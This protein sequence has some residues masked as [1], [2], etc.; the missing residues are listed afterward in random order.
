MRG[1]WICPERLF[2]GAK[3][4]ENM[5]LRLVD[6]RIDA[7]AL[8]SA[9]MADCRPIAGTLTPGFVDLQ[10][11]GG[12]G[13]L[14]NQTPT[15]EGLRQIVDAHR[16]LGTVAILPTVI[17]DTPEVLAAAVDAVIAAKKLRGI[18]GLHIEGP[19]IA[20]TR[21][22]THA[23]KFMR[24]FDPQTLAHV[25]RLRDEGVRVMITLAPEAAS[26]AD[27]T[28][29]TNLGAVVSLGHT[30][31]SADITRAAFGAGARCVTH[32]SNA[33]P[34]MFNREVGVMGAAI[35]SDAYAG[36]ICDGIH[37]ADEMV[38]LIVRARAVS[39]RMFLVSDAMPT[40]GGSD[41]FDLYGSEIRL[42][43]GRLVNAEGSLAGAHITQAEGV[44]RLVQH[45]GIGLEQAL[46]M[47]ITAPATLMGVD[48]LTI[49]EGRPIGDFLVL[50]DALEIRGTLAEIEIA[51]AA[52]T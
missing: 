33:M 26:D 37:V 18:V 7:V 1:I 20:A 29:L 17:S 49:V 47:A 15:Q 28:A 27:I 41:H 40:V 19:H 45:V 46:Q 25:R 3:L 22:G 32:I 5:A 52:N 10:V 35:N 16:K 21:R 14:F 6:G 42:D 36:I 9:E 38:G 4:R 31:A 51:D 12:G 24:P 39:D 11:N 13:I 34:P 50:D 8:R 44:A 2:D 30:D 48:E 43:N 23:A